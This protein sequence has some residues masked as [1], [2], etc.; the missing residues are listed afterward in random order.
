MQKTKTIQV[1]EPFEG[2]NGPITR[3][4]LREPTFNE[5]I[6]LGDPWTVALSEKHTPFSVENG[7]VISA[8][9]DRCI[10]EP[11]RIVVSKGGLALARKVKETFL[12]FF[13]PGDEVDV[14]STTSPMNSSSSAAPTSPAPGNSLSAN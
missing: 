12:S 9:L 7:D 6:L 2:H 11:D 5:Y 10:L 14:A 1:T 3:V 4:V 13:R 8:Y